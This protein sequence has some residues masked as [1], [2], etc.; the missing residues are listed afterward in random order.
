MKFELVG[1]MEEENP[2]GLAEGHSCLYERKLYVPKVVIDEQHPQEGLFPPNYEE[3]MQYWP[4][5]IPLPV[6]IVV[7]GNQWRQESS[8]NHYYGVTEY[9][10]EGFPSTVLT[11]PNGAT[12][13]YTEMDPFREEEPEELWEGDW[14]VYGEKDSE[15]L[16]CIVDVVDEAYSLSDET[17]ESIL[18]MRAQ[19]KAYSQSLGFELPDDE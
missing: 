11:M 5:G 13:T 6:A 2:D 15:D 14:S 17:P 4:S 1:P 12:L 18:E 19:Q 16:N 7:L 3:Y 9:E 8:Y 10:W